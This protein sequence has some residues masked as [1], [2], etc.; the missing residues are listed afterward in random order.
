MVDPMRSRLLDETVR[1]LAEAEGPITQLGA[2]KFLKQLDTALRDK[3]NRLS[4]GQRI[5]ALVTL[6]SGIEIAVSN[7]GAFEP[8]MI[9]VDGVG[10]DG[11]K[12]H[13]IT[14][15]NAFHLILREST[16]TI[17]EAQ[18]ERRIGFAVSVP[19]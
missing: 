16:G 6:P 10:S 7:I 4:E 17:N 2:K 8:S 19:E 15:L 12:Y 13:L 5:D 3:A 11:N 9:I 14:H 1:N 18:P